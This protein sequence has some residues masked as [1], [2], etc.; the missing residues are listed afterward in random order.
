[1][2]S[3]SSIPPVARKEC[4][5]NFCEKRLLSKSWQIY[6]QS[7]LKPCYLFIRC[8]E[9]ISQLSF[10]IA[11]KCHLD[12]FWYFFIV[13]YLSGSGRTPHNLL[14]RHSSQVPFGYQMHRI[15][16]T[17]YRP[18]PFVLWVLRQ[19]LFY[20]SARSVLWRTGPV[21]RRIRR[22]KKTFLS[23]RGFVSFMYASMHGT[24]ILLLSKHSLLLLIEIVCSVL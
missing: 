6:P 1:M 10:V 18:F 23:M 21:P 5:T 7:P 11:H 16:N 24:S 19:D 3:S 22:R 8:W 9:D 20:Y 12:I 14:S 17:G 13:I 15:T 4:K 2:Y